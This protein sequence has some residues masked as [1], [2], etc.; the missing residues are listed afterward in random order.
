VNPNQIAARKAL[1]QA[2][3]ALQRGEK[4]LARQYAGQAARLAPEIEEVWLMMA[5]LASPHASVAYLERALQINPHSA[6]AQKG[7]AWAAERWRKEALTSGQKAVPV[8]VQRAVV[9]PDVPPK[10][11]LRAKTAG[12]PRSI[13]MAALLMVLCL[14]STGLLWMGATPALAFLNENFFTGRQIGSAPAQVGP[15]V[16][17]AVQLTPDLVADVSETPLPTLTFTPTPSPTVTFTPTVTYTPTSTSAPTLP[18]TETETLIPTDVPTEIASPTPLSTDTPEPIPT[19]YVPTPLPGVSGASG[20]VHWIDV[21]L[22]HQMVYA[23]EGKTIVNSFLVS[24]GTAQHRTIT[25]SFHIYEK[26]L[27]ANMWGPGYF[28]PD[29]PYTMY[30]QKGYALHGT[31]WHS[32]FGTPMSHGCV[33]LYTPDAEWL[34]YWATMGTLVKVHY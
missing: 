25:G 4:R 29:V 7:L 31:Y 13:T 9:V 22:T 2:Q 11:Q 19:R 26:H 12:R 21:D 28:L 5:A 18:P 17:P 27:T 16:S 20:G 1:E 24:T 30:F 8:A 23:Y 33:N 3:Q 14:I 15:V 6:R 34:Y 10:A 32:N